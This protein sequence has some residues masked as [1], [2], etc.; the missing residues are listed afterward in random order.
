MRNRRRSFEC[1]CYP[2]HHV[3][4]RPPG[5]TAREAHA[6][7]RG[8][9]IGYHA[10]RGIGHNARLKEFIVKKRQYDPQLR[11]SNLMWDKYFT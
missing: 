11:F 5:I 2:R 6:K 1:V 3:S 9:N 10:G 4:H 8:R 7:Q